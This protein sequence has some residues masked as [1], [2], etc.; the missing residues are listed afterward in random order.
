MSKATPL[1]SAAGLGEDFKVQDL[2]KSGKA[3]DVNAGD[4]KVIKIGG[5]KT[6][7]FFPN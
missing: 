4:A 5:P 3:G 2:I 7:I 1:Q 6:R